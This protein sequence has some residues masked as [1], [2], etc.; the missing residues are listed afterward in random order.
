MKIIFPNFLR[1]VTPIIQGR[2][3]RKETNLFLFK[4]G[5]VCRLLL[6]IFKLKMFSYQHSNYN[7]KGKKRKNCTICKWLFTPFVTS[8]TTLIK[9]SQLEI[10]LR[11]SNIEKNQ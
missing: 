1:S 2:L 4:W 10:T 6:L 7:K 9:S 8:I 5:S 3:E 11:G